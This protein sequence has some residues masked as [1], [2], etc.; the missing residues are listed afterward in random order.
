MTR[1]EQ[2]HHG[3]DDLV[4]VELGR[5][6]VGDQVVGRLRAYGDFGTWKVKIQQHAPGKPWKTTHTLTT[7]GWGDFSKKIE[8]KGTTWFRAV[9]EQS[10]TTVAAT[11]ASYKVKKK[12]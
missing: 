5:N 9:H 11:S 8:I 10:N 3:G 2:Q 1:V 7:N 6:Q 4:V 12:K